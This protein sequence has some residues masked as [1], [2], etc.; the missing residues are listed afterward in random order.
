MDDQKPPSHWRDPQSSLASRAQ[1]STNPPRSLLS[2]ANIGPQVGESGRG[3]VLHL[4]T[5]FLETWAV[6]CGHSE[7]IFFC[8][9]Y[10]LRRNH[11]FFVFYPGDMLTLYYYISLYF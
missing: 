11:V 1:Y 6:N 2:I 3:E 7:N 8:Y 9:F 10:Q 4:Y 5:S